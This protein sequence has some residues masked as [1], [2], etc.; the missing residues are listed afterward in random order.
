G[1]IVGKA[2][3]MVIT[4][5]EFEETMLKRYRSVE[6][7]EKRSLKDRKELA[8]QIAENKLKL[9]DAYAK[10]I[11]KDSLVVAKADEV[12][13]QSAIQD[14]YKV[15]ILDKVIPPEAIQEEY[16]KT[17]EEIH[18]KHILF[19]SYTDMEPNELEVL[20]ERAEK[21]YALLQDGADFDSLAK[22]MSEDVTTA[23]QGGDLGYFTWGKMVDEFQ[24]TAFKL[25]PGEMSD[26]V[27]SSY[28]FHII[29]LLDRRPSETRQPFEEAEEN[30][31]MGLRRK[32]TD[33]LNKGA[34]DYLAG[35]KEDA[36]LKF[37]YNR[38]QNILDKVSDPDV[39]RNNSYFANFSAEE[40]Q[41][42]IAW[43]GT[44]TIRVS[45]LEVEI[46]KTGRPPQ[47]RDQK[48]IIQMIDRM[49]LPD[50]LSDRA[51]KIGLYKSKT[52]REA[53]KLTLEMEMMR[54]IE[55]IE[56]DEKITLD[57]DVLK[58]YY[59]SHH[60]DFMTDSTVEVQEIYVLVD[61]EKGKDRDYAQ[62]LA[63]RARKGEDFTTLVKKY[64]ERK[65][66]LGRDGKIG[67]ITS[68]Q[69][70]AMGQEAFK[71]EIGETS[72]PIKMGRRGWS[73][74]KLLDKSPARLKDYEESKAQV[75][76][77]ARNS[78]SDE[79]KTA[80]MDGLKKRYPITIYDDRLM[81]VL[82]IPEGA[83]A[84]TTKQPEMKTIPISKGNN[85]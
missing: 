70:G 39:P 33:E 23:Q 52:V 29:K 77:L 68:R 32:F 41:W 11:D 1:E 82:P 14:L 17:A 56:V 25:K 18:A 4:A 55:V 38:I 27:Q 54:R 75:E 71:L 19:K 64:S 84:D 74:I 78:Q 57:E 61:E 5:Q 8:E 63:V 40:K 44:D 45:D 62:K 48:A 69:Y 53:Y 59:N 80:W 60:A 46:A 7:A 2:G 58:E 20:K 72:D 51:E 42:S 67:P 83:A 36:G 6:F 9:Q 22:N 79:L 50:L 47:W 65:S 24:E 66:A 34:E 21:C 35:L 28:G 76:R 13:K 3:K 81:T 12:R 73:V 85:E 10:G 49:V 31:R 37:N 15:E 16:D 30:I 43:M 26:I